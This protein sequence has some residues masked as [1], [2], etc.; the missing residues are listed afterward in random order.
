MCYCVLI[1]RSDM[2]KNYVHSE[3][4]SIPKYNDILNRSFV[5]HF[6]FAIRCTEKQ[7]EIAV[8]DFN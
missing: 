4:K 2:H 1:V 5:L 3:D 8:I 7:T 6:Y